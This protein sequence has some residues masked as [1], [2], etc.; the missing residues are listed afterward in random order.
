MLFC[1]FLDTINHICNPF[2]CISQ[3]LSKKASYS[4]SERI[5]SI[6]EIGPSPHHGVTLSIHQ[7]CELS[8]L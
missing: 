5:N 4:L 7:V 1:S 3:S 2:E 6:L 8:S